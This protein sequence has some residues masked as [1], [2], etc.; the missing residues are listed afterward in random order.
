[1]RLWIAGVGP[2]EA[3]TR[4]LCGE[5]GL[6]ADVTFLGFVTDLPSL[7]A[8]AD[9]Q[10]HP[11]NI[12]G[13]PLA[14]CEGMAAGLPIIASAVGGL[15]EILDEGRN[16]VLVAPADEDAFVEAVLHM[17]DDRD[18]A[19]RYGAQARHFIENDYSLTTAVRKVEQTYAEMMG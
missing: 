14:I 4:A 17:I 15:P 2:L 19:R 1:M 18:A 13:V 11:A 7:L 16:G 3:Q 6:D 9:I 12:E 5:M 10:V 8:L